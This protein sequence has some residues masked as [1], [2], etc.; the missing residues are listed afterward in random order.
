[1]EIA[2]LLIRRE[3]LKKQ[4][5]Q[6]GL[7]SGICAVS[8]L[9]KIEQGKAGASE[10][11]MSMLFERLG[12]RWSTEND[13]ETSKWLEECWSVFF[14]G[15]DSA[16]YALREEIASRMEALGGSRFAI[17]ILLLDALSRG[18]RE[19]L[20][21][22]FE[23]F[24]TVRQLALQR[25]LQLRFG[26]AVSLYPAPYFYLVHGRYHYCEGRYTAAMELLRMAYDT[27]AEEGL[28]YIMLH[29]RI[30]MGNCCSDLGDLKRMLEHYTV[31]GR[32]AS[33]L[34][35]ADMLSSIR[36]NIA[37]TNL[38]CGNVG[39]AYDYFSKKPEPSVMEL[40]KLAICC[41]KLGLVNEALS[42]LDRASASAKPGAPDIDSELESKLL[43]LVRY[44]LLHG[45]YLEDAC[46]GR[47]LLDCFEELREKLPLGYAAFHLPWVLE[48]YKANRQYKQACALLEDFPQK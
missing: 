41:E 24:M 26:D 4:W 6:E 20:D 22:D 14:S 23:P 31:A 34:G 43:E 39:E 27:A 40:H 16:F 38:Q 15:N 19:P 13:G 42:A 11:I 18:A 30:Y 33:A 48:W 2:G 10:E 47:L 29:S 9:S 5:S 37:A 17:D 46:Y 7:C 25:I 44:R 1:M 21:R 8:Y 36:Y 3:R 28:A 35:Q 45:D 32:L 12:L